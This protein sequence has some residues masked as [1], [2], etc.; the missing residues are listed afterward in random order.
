MF[1]LAPMNSNPGQRL[2]PPAEDCLPVLDVTI[3]YEDFETGLRGKGVLELVSRELELPPQ[4]KIEFWKLDLF[5]EPSLRQKAARAAGASEVVILS[6][7]GQD[8]V[9]VA[10]ER[11][12]EEWLE[13]KK[14]GSSAFV[15][16]LDRPEPEP[17]D[18]HPILD[19]I[20]RATEKAGADF[21]YRYCDPNT[22]ELSVH[23]GATNP[24]TAPPNEDGNSFPSQGLNE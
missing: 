6:A 20:R 4:F 18:Q 3:L 12:V 19:L 15:A 22:T 23:P 9:P 2:A 21:F 16:L 11:W 8:G 24:P 10:F 14:D 13:E 1:N 17:A 7:H 5:Q